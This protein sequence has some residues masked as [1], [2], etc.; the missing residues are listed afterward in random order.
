MRV[1][2]V[3]DEPLARRGLALRLAA[4]A[5]V[6]LA[7]LAGS[8]AEAAARLSREPVDVVLLD[9]GM[10]GRDGFALTGHAGQ[11]PPPLWIFVT[12]HAEHALRAFAVEAL[13]YLLKPVD[14]AALARALDRARHRLALRPPAPGA[15]GGDERL[16]VRDGARTQR[17]PLAGIR[18]IEAAG[19]YAC[20]HTADAACV[21]RE[22][23]SSL[24]ARLDPARFVRIHRSAIVGIGH[25]AAIRPH[26]NGERVIELDGGRRLKLSRGYRAALARLRAGEP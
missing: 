19:D 2:I 6:R 20:I 4:H 22:T 18:W 12:A 15:A 17:I 10:P 13:D 26:R 7:G 23:L 24:E 11:W 5:D 8:V 14:A 25:V 21:V 9:I 16:I 1:L 3:D